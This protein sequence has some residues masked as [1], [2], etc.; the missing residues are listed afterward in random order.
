MKWYYV[1]NGQQAGPVEETQLPELVQSGRLLD[2]TL[3]WHEGMA[4]WQPFSAVRPPGSAATEA[5]APQLGS[6]PPEADA[7]DA[8]CVECNQMFPKEEMIRHKDVYVCANCKPI[9]MQKLGEGI[10]T[11]VR[12]GRRTL[13]VDPDALIAEIEA[14]GYEVDIGD[15][16]SRGWALYKANFGVCVGATFLVMLCNQA[17]G[18]I[19]FIGI[20]ISLLVQGPLIG[21]LNLFFI[22]LIRGEAP[23]VGEAFSGFSKGFWRLCGT[24]LLMM[25]LL[26][27]WFIP[28][29][30]AAYAIPQN[31][32]AFWITVGSLGLAGFVVMMY[33]A[34]S[35]AFALALS[36]D[37]EL[38]PWDSMRVSRRVVS[39]RWFSLFG[40]ILVAG[41]LSMLGAIA[42][43]IGVI[44]TMPILYVVTL[45]A[46]EDIFGARS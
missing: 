15:T 39:K 28:A 10:V 29:G 9:F 19:P 23:G 31:S 22:K 42:C 34:V 18:F 26:Y 30:V 1:E 33:F 43:I 32:N 24:L 40:L 16:I 4:E 11:G 8:V 44:F 46:Y 12:S 2:D 25:L 6:A 14:R 17:A 27:V 38:G 35:F 13:P 20:I 5:A 37:L 3:V 41:L 36:A 21:G 45:Q 7:T